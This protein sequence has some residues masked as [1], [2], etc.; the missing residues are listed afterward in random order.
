M[1]GST[2]PCPP[3]AESAELSLRAMLRD[4]SSGRHVRL[5]TIWAELVA[6]QSKIHSS[7]SSETRNY[8]LLA[9]PRQ[10]GQHAGRRYRGRGARCKLRDLRIVETWFANGSQKRVALELDLSTSTVA[11]ATKRWLSFVGLRCLPSYVP[12]LL[13]MAGRPCEREAARAEARLTE[14][15]VDDTCYRVVSAL[16]PD[17]QLSSLL[18]RAEYE[19]V[20]LFLEGRSHKEVAVL[21]GSSPRTVAN[22]LAM[23]FHR[24]G[25]SGRSELVIHLLRADAQR[26]TAGVL[27]T[28]PR[29][30]AGRDSSRRARP[31]SSPLREAA[32]P[33]V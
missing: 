31:A 28:H 21:R 19:V 7:F 6:G 1:D 26:G 30:L 32:S 25:V 16:R 15:L 8:F 2:Q 22:Q 11:T 10:P 14:L 9:D 5:S 17:N 3:A 33:L 4:A 18:P 27:V 29:P 13:M 23:V 12:P 20:R 24:F